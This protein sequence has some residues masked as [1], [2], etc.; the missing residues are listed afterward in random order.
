MTTITTYQ[1]QQSESS[2]WIGMILSKIL[3][4]VQFIWTGF[5]YCPVDELAKSTVFE[6]VGHKTIGGS[7]PPRTAKLLYRITVNIS[8]FDPEDLGSIPSRV[9]KT[10]IK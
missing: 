4:P 7:T 9:T 1:Q 3:K 2:D 5:F 10:K 6:T 8:A